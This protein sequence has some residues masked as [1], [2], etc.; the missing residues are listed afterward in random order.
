[1]SGTVSTLYATAQVMSKHYET[2]L[3]NQYGD[4]WKLKE[5]NIQEHNSATNEARQAKNAALLKWQRAAL[6][7]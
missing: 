4:S 6:N 7:K 2:A 3:R 1:M 5:F